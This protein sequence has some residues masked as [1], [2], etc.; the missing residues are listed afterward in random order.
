MRSP[1]KN[2][3]FGLSREMDSMRKST[4]RPTHSQPV[5]IQNEAMTSRDGE[6]FRGWRGQ[7]RFSREGGRLEGWRG[8]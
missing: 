6:Y 1:T 4:P 3:D 5:N 8:M 7:P 2:T